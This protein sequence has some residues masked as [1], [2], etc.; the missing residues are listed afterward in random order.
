[1]PQPVHH[2]LQIADRFYFAVFDHPAPSASQLNANGGTE[3]A[4]FPTEPSLLYGSWVRREYEAQVEQARARGKRRDRR[5]QPLPGK[6]PDQFHWFSID[7][8]LQYSCFFDDWGPLNAA[9]LFRFCTEVQNLMEVSL[10]SLLR[11]RVLL[12]R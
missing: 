7:E 12:H 11:R 6:I 8:R 10:A 1:M 4:V 5:W 2:L 9:A 3:A